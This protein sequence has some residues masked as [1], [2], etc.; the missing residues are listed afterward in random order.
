M[1]LIAKL[2]QKR[3]ITPEDLTPEE[4]ETVQQWEKTLSDEEVTVESISLFCKN[5]LK[6]IEQQ[7]KDTNISR[8]KMERL[9][10]L[11]SV[12]ASLRDV[13]SSPKIERASLES[14]LTSLL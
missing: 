5:Q 8:E 6:N 10:L 12:Y 11:H 4:K 13:I 9:V 2:F 3:G 14:Y 1:N 7:F